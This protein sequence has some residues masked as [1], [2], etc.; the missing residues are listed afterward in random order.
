MSDLVGKMILVYFSAHW[1]PPCRAFTPKLIET[2][3]KIK[4]KENAFEVIF[5]SSDRDEASFDD[6]FSS[7]PWMALPFGDE[8]KQSL[9]RRFKVDGIP[10]LVAIGPTGKTITTEARELIMFHGA[11]AY[12][13]TEERVKEIE[14]HYAE[15]TKGWPDKLKHTL[16]EH[17][18][19]LTRSQFYTCDACDE[20]GKVWAFR[21]EECDYDLH[22][23]CALE[24]KKINEEGVEG[25]VKMEENPKEGWVCD[26]DVC[27]KA[28]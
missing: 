17:E 1:C 6:Y 16:H 11:D 27:Y 10:L 25:N 28:S 15:M 5:V 20:E 23:K 19:V 24:D 21:C 26:G 3:R 9:K 2:Y 4:E 8:R 13:F 7:M 18:L 12:P 14:T 22:P